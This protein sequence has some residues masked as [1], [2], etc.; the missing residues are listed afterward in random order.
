LDSS[1]N[2]EVLLPERDEQLALYALI[3]RASA[4]TTIPF[5]AQL[6]SERFA[7]L[8]QVFL[9]SCNLP[10]LL[11]KEKLLSYT[12]SVALYILLFCGGVFLQLTFNRFF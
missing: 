4:N 2:N 9:L 7:R 8:N 1:N 11:R 12:A 6:F 5:L 10:E 3:A